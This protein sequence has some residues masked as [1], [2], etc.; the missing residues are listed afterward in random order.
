MAIAPIDQV[1]AVLRYAT[2]VIDP[3]KILMGMALYGYDWPL[4]YP[5][6]GHA[7][8]LAND[9][10][11]A[12][13]I[14]TQSNVNWSSTAQSPWF[15]YR[16]ADTRTHEVWFEDAASV[17]AKIQLVYDY[18]LRGLSYWVLGNA[19]TQNWNLVRDNFRVVK[20]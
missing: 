6:A 17:A 5:Q 12:L 7:S 11:Q 4:P 20:S 16:S 10:A 18:N 19:F 13:A 14:R 15:R 8:G 2:S 1:R 3:R 9:A